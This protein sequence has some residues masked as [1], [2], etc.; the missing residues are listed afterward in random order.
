MKISISTGIVANALLAVAA[1]PSAFGESDTAALDANFKEYEAVVRLLRGS[2]PD[3]ADEEEQRSSQNVVL[4][5]VS[6]QKRST[7]LTGLVQ[8][9]RSHNNFEDV[10]KIES[11]DVA[12]IS[13]NGVFQ[14][15]LAEQL[16]SRREFLEWYRNAKKVVRSPKFAAFNHLEFKLGSHDLAVMIDLVMS[17]KLKVPKAVK[18][19]IKELKGTQFE[20]WIISQLTK[21]FVSE[22]ILGHPKGTFHPIAEKYGNHVYKNRSKKAYIYT[23]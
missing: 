17:K 11:L 14:K 4:K 2:T 10:F 6:L 5:L 9:V 3:E 15:H 21:E 1:F 7:F 22:T 16:L 12:P 18:K 20:K 13:E 8:S 23:P 19:V